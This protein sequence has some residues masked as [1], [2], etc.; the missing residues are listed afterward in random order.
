MAKV[1]DVFLIYQFL[2]RLVTPFDRWEAFKTGVIDQDGQVIIDKR[3]RSVEQA[4]SWGYYDRLLAN[5]KKMLAKIPGGRTRLGSFAA[6]L[7]LLREG[8]APSDDDVLLEQMLERYMSEAETLVDDNV[9]G[10][11]AIAGLGIGDQGE[12]PVRKKKKKLRRKQLEESYW[13]EE[14]W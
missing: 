11:G 4:K 7:L 9:V 1:L 14:I 6:A 10:G 2:R 13:S 12:P 8:N 5:L 3:G